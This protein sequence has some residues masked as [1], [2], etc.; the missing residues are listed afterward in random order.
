MKVTVFTPTYNR[1]YI[2]KY[3]Y[4]SLMRQTCMDFEWLVI[5]DGSTDNTQQIIDNFSSRPNP[6]TIRYYKIENGGKHRA[7]NKAVQLAENEL[8]FIV[9]SDDYLTSDAIECILNTEQTIPEEE[10]HRFAGVCLKKGYSETEFVGTTFNGNVL[11]ITM[12]EREKNG[13]T[14]DQAEVFYTDIL[15]KYPFPEYEGEKFVTECVVW[16]KIAYDG[17]K[18][19]FV[20]K[21]IYICNY[22]ENGLSAHYDLLLKNNPIGY[23][24]YIYQCGLFGKTFGVKKWLEYWKY[25]REYKEKLGLFAVSKNLHINP[26]ALYLR[27]LGLR[28]FYKIYDR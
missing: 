12:L 2:I 10:K 22:Q 13:I 18:L 6:F 14:G 20:N 23:G 28:V 19:R 7:I 1:G 15:K 24:Q 9:D 25:Y 16:D 11:D 5:D 8:F 27:I 26:I 17:Y 4:E 3:L 21:I